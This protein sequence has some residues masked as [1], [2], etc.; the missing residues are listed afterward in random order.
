MIGILAIF[1]IS[2]LIYVGTTSLPEEQSQDNTDINDDL[3]NGI[4]ENVVATVNGEKITKEEVTTNQQSYVQQGLQISEEQA[5]EQLINQT[6]LTQQAQ[7]EGVMLTDEETESDLENQLLQQ[8]LT[9]EKYK[10]QLEQQGISYEEQLQN[11]KEQL[12][13]LNYLDDVLEGENINV[14]E[15]EAENY[16]DWSKQQSEEELPPYEEVESQIINYLQ[17]QKQEEAIKSLVQELRKDAD[18]EYN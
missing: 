5:L 4:T 6:I 1:A 3:N 7:Q 12:T 2:L 8:N 10:Q 14:T 9:L 11:Y 16:Y 15:E 17:Q 18:I 13:L